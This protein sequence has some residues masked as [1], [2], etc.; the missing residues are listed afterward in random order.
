MMK[1]RKNK[2]PMMFPKR[3]ET[4]FGVTAICMFVFATVVYLILPWA[5]A[6]L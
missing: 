6:A 1:T 4:A 5:E 3:R 2:F